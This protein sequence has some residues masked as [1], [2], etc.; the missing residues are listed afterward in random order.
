MG[1]IEFEVFLFEDARFFEKL[2]T[3]A[4][5]DGLW[6]V[7]A[8]GVELFIAVEEGEIE[9]GEIGFDVDESFGTEGFFGGVIG[10]VL[11]EA[12]AEGVDVLFFYGESCGHFVS[13]AFDEEI[14]AGIEGGDEGDAGD[15]ASAAFADAVFIDGDD[16][17]GEVMFAGDA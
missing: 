13:A 2:H 5:E 7:A 12:F 8:E 1:E 6:V 10:D 3:A 15:G 9:V 11:G 16:E 17:G 14:A 4:E